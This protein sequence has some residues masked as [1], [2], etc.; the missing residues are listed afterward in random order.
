MDRSD[1]RIQT[2]RQTRNRSPQRYVKLMKQ[3][4]LSDR[5]T[6]Y[7]KFFWLVVFFYLT[8]YGSV[9]V[10]SIEDEEL[11]LATEC[12]IAH[13]GQCPMQLFYRPHIK[14]RDRFNRQN[15]QTLAAT[16]GLYD[17]LQ[18]NKSLPFIGSPISYWVH[19]AAPPPRSAGQRR[20]RCCTAG[21]WSSCS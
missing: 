15:R 18:T 14:K 17:S 16:L 12:Q 8:Y 5:M 2:A 11:R 19:L 13:F 6:I 10:A 4:H 3:L 1:I 9:D 21:L 20:R 7:L